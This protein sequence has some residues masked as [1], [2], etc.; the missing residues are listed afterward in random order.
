MGEYPKEGDEKRSR[1]ILAPVDREFLKGEKEY[2]HRQSAYGR[3]EKIR[4]RVKNG[5]LDFSLLLDLPAEEREKIF[6]SYGDD[7]EFMPAIQ[8]ALAFLYLGVADKTGQ[9]K[10]VYKSA[11]PAFEH[12]LEEGLLRALLKHE[13]IL[14]ELDLTISAEKFDGLETALEMAREGEELSPGYIRLLLHS[15]A[16]DWEPVHEVIHEQLLELE[17]SD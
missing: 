1:G 7:P 5:L 9:A 4:E 17:E 12:D 13:Y 16:V 2:S 6:E 3:R 14:E 8:H 15:D 10:G 11:N